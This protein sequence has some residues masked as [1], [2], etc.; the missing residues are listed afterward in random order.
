MPLTT[1]VPSPTSRAA[2]SIGLLRLGLAR[3]AAGQ[4]NAVGADA[5]DMNVGIR[6]DALERGAHAVEVAGDGDVEAGDLAALRVEEED[7][8]LPDRRRRS[9]RRGATER[10]TAL[11]IL[12]SATK[13]SLMSAGRSIATDL[14]T[15]SGTKRELASL[16][17]IFNTGTREFN[18]GTRE[19]AA[20]AG[21]S[22]AS[23]APSI[24]PTSAAVRIS[25]AVDMS[26]VPSLIAV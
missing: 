18:T 14:P 19:S 25:G 6:H 20:P 5:F 10:T 24:R 16:D 15:P 21:T 17:V 9:C 22:G 3:G 4:H 1:L 26:P 13:T 8:G 11:A 12:G 7:V 23:A 2:M